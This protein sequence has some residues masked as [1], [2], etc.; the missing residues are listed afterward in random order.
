MAKISKYIISVS[1][2]LTGTLH[3]QVKDSAIVQYRGIRLGL[4]LSRFAFYYFQ[5]SRKDFEVM[6]DVQ[7]KDNLF[8]AGEAGWNH[9]QFH[10]SLLQYRSNGYFGRAGIDYNLLQPEKA[11]EANILYIGARYGFGIFTHEAPLYEVKD[12][13]YGTYR[14][15]ISPRTRNASWLEFVAGLKVEILKNLFLGWNLRAKTLLKKNVDTELTP[16]IIPGFGKGAQ[17]SNFD[18]NYSV[19]Y[20][21]PIRLKKQLKIHPAAVGTV[22]PPS[23]KK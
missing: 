8:V 9:T 11:G 12:P 15:S 13:Y 18:V 20:R 5:P 4:D 16:Y 10:N 2:L 21:I 22:S 19:Y 14:G 23:T 3:A 7:V 6:A 17:R 1:L